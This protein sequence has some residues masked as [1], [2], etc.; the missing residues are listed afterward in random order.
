MK[1]LTACLI[2]LFF[3]TL[4]AN[5][6]LPES[7]WKGTLNIPS[8]AECLFEFK[9]DT[10][11]LYLVA[12][13]SLIETMSYSTKGDSLFLTKVNGMSP[14]TGET[15]GV[16]RFEIKEDK[17]YIK[18]LSDDCQERLEAFTAD[19]WIREKK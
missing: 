13:N 9:K 3:I 14:C 18:P 6:Q 8:P 11:F 15:K 17:L 19:A 1:Q 2:A 5:A 7:K 4:S 16:Y 12:D 10:V